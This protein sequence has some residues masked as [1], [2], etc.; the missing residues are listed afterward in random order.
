MT[1]DH[2]AWIVWPGYDTAWWVM[3]LH[4]IG[5]ITAPIMWFFA[6]EGYHHTGNL[7]NYLLRMSVFAAV[8]HFAYAFA[9]NIPFL[10]FSTGIFNQTSVLLSLLCGLLMLTVIDSP[11]LPGWGKIL[12]VAGLA[13]V[14]LP[15]D[16]SCI[17]ALAVLAIGVNRGS[18]RR[19]MSWMMLL[20][21]LYSAVFFFAA[22]RIYAI[23][24]LFTALSIPILKLYNGERGKW[25]GMKWF[26]YLYYPLHLALAGLLRIAI[27]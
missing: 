7:R 8:S 22:D 9:M 13:V 3:L 25:K 10:P 4:A 14:S 12:L 18:F 11:S 21:F 24:Q 17:G 6:A 16:W 23:L 26:F 19:Q 27:R 2:I 20:V 15:A 5:R 1:V